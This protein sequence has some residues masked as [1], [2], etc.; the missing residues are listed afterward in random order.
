MSSFVRAKF[1][2]KVQYGYNNAEFDAA[3][4]SVENVAK[5]LMQKK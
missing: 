3:F 4:E 1:F 5:K 2:P